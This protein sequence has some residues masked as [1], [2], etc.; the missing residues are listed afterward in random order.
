MKAVVL[1]DGRELV[2]EDRPKPQTAPGEVLVRSHNCGI[3]GSDLHATSLTDIF[4]PN[5]VMGHEFAG[6]VVD[7]G[8]GVSGWEPGDRVTINPNG[9]TCGTCR[10][11][12]A[13]RF[14]LCRTTVLGRCVGA[15]RDGGM[16]AYVNLP[17]KVLHRVPDGVSMLQAA[18]V[19]PLAIAL[20]V[21]N[22]SGISEGGSALVLG[23]GPIGLLTLQALRRV[24]A[25]EITVVEP[26]PFRR[27]MAE[28]LGADHTVDPASDD[29]I[30]LFGRDL[31]QPEYVFECAGIPRGI[32]IG[33][34]V[35]QPKGCVA[36]VGICPEPLELRVD[37][38]IFKEVVVKG[39][40]IYV[41]EFPLAIRLLEQD[42][43]DVETMTS[44]ILPLESFQEGFARLHNGEDA[45]KIQLQP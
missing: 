11:C 21:V 22:V 10:E 7:V 44:D 23:A 3:C 17:E 28:R 37:E 33:L 31:E 25:R 15:Q 32:A 20:R 8:E 5:I 6:E 9:D 12:R 29:P 26:L 36:V 43:I 4:V 35:V 39:S 45:I 34:A 30:E 1:R 19:E 18:W 24:G 13:G 41:E 16:A 2:L 42:E 14:N 38:L 40:I 27:Q